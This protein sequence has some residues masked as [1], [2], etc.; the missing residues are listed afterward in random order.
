M[1]TV[2]APIP[3]TQQRATGTVVKAFGNLLSVKFEGN[4]RQG[5]IA[6]VNVDGVPLKSEVIEIAGD[7]AK[8]QVYEDTR[9]VALN[10][11][12]QFTGDLLEAE[13]GPGLLKAILDGLQNPLEDVAN[14][15]GLF[16]VRGVYLPPLDR[17]KNWDY[18]PAAKVGETLE[19]GEILGSTMEG[20][21]KHFIMVPFAL[22]GQY[23]LTWIIKAGSY[24]IDTVVAKAQDENGQEIAFSMVQKWPVKIPLHEGDKIKPS[25]MM[26]TGSRI[27]D[28]QFPIMKGGDLL[29]AW[30]VWS[31]Q[32]CVTA[33]SC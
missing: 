7:E 15:A 17:K 20:R 8:I 22:F 2:T 24:T 9:G 30:S 3:E 5:E 23:K 25:K 33:P 4:I 26:D 27:I 19:R 28:T 21:F 13:L 16:L 18:T 1:K 31:G 6:M 11:P 14:A 12:V 10:T 32:D 29:H